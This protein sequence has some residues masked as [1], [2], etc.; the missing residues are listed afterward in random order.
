MQ[1]LLL[2]PLPLTPAVVMGQ[3]N[4]LNIQRILEGALGYQRVTVSITVA[5]ASSDLSE[6]H[7]PP[8]FRPEVCKWVD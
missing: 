2:R 6:R 3:P 5:I 7:G 1:L 4:A 8:M